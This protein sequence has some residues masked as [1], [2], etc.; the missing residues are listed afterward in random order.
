MITERV[1]HR[2]SPLRPASELPTAVVVFVVIV[3]GVLIPLI[4]FLAIVWMISR[5]LRD[6]RKQVSWE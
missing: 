2:L 6:V 4:P 1:N 5:T 3:L